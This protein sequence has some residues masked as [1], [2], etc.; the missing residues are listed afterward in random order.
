MREDWKAD[1][2]RRLAEDWATIWQSEQ[3]AR[4]ADPETGH[5]V[6]AIFDAWLRAAG[7][8]THLWPPPHEAG[9]YAAPRPAPADAAPDAGADE[10]AALR[11]RL[12]ELERRMAAA[13]A[14]AAVP[15]ATVINRHLF[16]S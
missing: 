6:R 9:T 3:A 15:I 8:V 14:L 7:G 10:I 13:A 2:I 12:D 5:M 1:R 11:R 16:P 4:G